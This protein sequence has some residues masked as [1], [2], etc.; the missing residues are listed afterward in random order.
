LEANDS[1]SQRKERFFMQETQKLEPLVI[2]DTSAIT[3]Q[4][5]KEIR[6][7]GIGGSE[8]A[9]VLGISPFTTARD[10]YYTKLGIPHEEPD[11]SSWVQFEIGHLLENLVAR[12]FHQKTGFPI[13]PANKMYK[14]SVHGFMSANL[15]YLTEDRDGPAV[16]EIKTTNYYAK[17][18]WWQDGKEIVPAYYEAQ[19]RH[20]MSV[21]DI[22][23]VYFC[24]LYGNSF[25]DVIIRQID[26]DMDYEAELV[27][28][29]QNFWNNHILAQ[30]PPPYTENGDL[31][32]ESV[33]RHYAYANPGT[34]EILLN[35]DHAA[36][37]AHYLELQQAKTE[38][39][40]RARAIDNRMKQIK[41]NLMDELG[42]GCLA[43]CNLGDTSYTITCKPSP[44]TNINKDN[45][46]LLK[47]QHP[48]IYE[49]FVTVS[50]NRQFKVKSV[51]LENVTESIDER[52]AA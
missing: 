17:D 2:A 35:Q 33:K 7:Q 36:P 9:S 19:G 34:P 31:V 22:N 40:R 30:I 20:Y 47:M 42:K 51:A 45:L 50:E 8:A 23:R 21:M 15:D 52:M 38:L 25:N 28:H 27:F 11:E 16:L 43:T 3:E 24:C 26:R 44:R 14:H 6:R 41:G 29:E 12:I 39:D 5:W 49:Q 13:F 37:L 48:E 4:E 46:L 32:L 18:N 1:K 10:L